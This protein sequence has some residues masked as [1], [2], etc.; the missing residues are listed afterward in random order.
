MPFDVHVKC[1]G[2][3]FAAIVE[4]MKKEASPEW[5]PPPDEVLV[6]T[7]DNFTNTVNNADLILVEFYA[8]W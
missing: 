6:L 4:F 7:A 2:T 3:S 1:G 8:P 5:R